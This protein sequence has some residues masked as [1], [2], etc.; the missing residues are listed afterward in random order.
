MTRALRAWSHGLACA[1][2]LAVLLS[3][4]ATPPGVQTTPSEVVAVTATAP[5]AVASPAPPD[6]ATSNTINPAPAPQGEKQPYLFA[7]DPLRPS[8][9][10]ESDDANSRRDLWLRVRA[11]FAMSDLDNEL[12]VKWQQWYASRPD[13][14]QRMTERGSRYLFHVVEEIDKRGMPTELA[15]L[16]FIESAFNPQAMST[17]INALSR[18]IENTIHWETTANIEITGP[19]PKVY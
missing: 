8:V 12:V 7:L 9:I 16:P 6:T 18:C 4:C 1:S 5:A 2:L 13:Y 19:M 14:V 15:L 11:G 17:A 3:G 10:V